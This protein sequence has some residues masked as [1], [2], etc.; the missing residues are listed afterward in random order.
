MIDIQKYHER[1]IAEIDSLSQASFPE[2]LNSGP[3]NGKIRRI[4]LY[5][6]TKLASGASIRDILN[7]DKFKTARR[8]LEAMSREGYL[9]RHGNTIA[10][11]LFS[12]N[13][14]TTQITY[15]WIPKCSCTSVKR[16]LASF[17]PSSLRVKIK[18]ARLHISLQELLGQT[19]PQFSNGKWLRR[20]AFV[21]DPYQ[22]IIS[23]YI[24]KF[25]I[26]THDK[27]GFEPFARR[28]IKNCISL[29]DLDRDA[30]ESISFKEFLQYIVMTPR[31]IH[32][33]H[34]LP[35]EAFLPLDKNQIQILPSN[36]LDLLI[37]LL[38]VDQEDL[39]IPLE[40]SRGSSAATK[41]ELKDLPTGCYW[42]C[43]PQGI[44]IECFASY[45][46]F[47]SQSAR[48]TIRSLYPEDSL[49][50]ETATRLIDTTS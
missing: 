7:E 15:T 4:D 39:Q 31:F 11:H 12:I 14:P 1:A 48:E 24:D 34:W 6:S 3:F 29:L 20:L 25:A 47:L 26:P 23:C 8:Y 38:K 30:S 49:V 33:A 40:N 9:G 43:L 37:R 16:L 18:R 21:R 10:P 13:F 2:W 27:R 22:R 5:V 36:R 41:Y 45:S 32:D 44:P 46:L 19:S 50:W 17:E 42:D 28:H 35:Q